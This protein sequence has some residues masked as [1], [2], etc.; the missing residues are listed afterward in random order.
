MP[1][2]TEQKTAKKWQEEFKVGLK[3]DLRRDFVTAIQCRELRFT[4]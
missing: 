4:C 1:T 2:E 3:C